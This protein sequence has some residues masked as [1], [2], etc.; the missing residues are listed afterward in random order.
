MSETV[1]PPKPKNISSLAFVISVLS[2]FSQKPAATEERGE[3]KEE[4]SHNRHLQD[5]RPR[6]AG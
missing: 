6:L 3:G 2:S 5:G 4:P 1:W